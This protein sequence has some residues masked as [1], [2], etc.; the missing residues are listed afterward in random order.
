[1]GP[2][3]PIRRMLLYGLVLG[4]LTFAVTP[5]SALLLGFPKPAGPVGAL[6][7]KD[8]GNASATLLQEVRWG[9]FCRWHREHR[10]CFKFVQL[11]R[12]CDRRPRHRLCDDDD[13]NRFCKKRPDHPLC[14]DDRFCKKRPDHPLCDDDDPP[15]PS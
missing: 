4:A 8:R 9:R 5:S 3:R 2:P 13:D 7:Y 10:L 15:S 11:L 6:L 1:M 12:F 14:D